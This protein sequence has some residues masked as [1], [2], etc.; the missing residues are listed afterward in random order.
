[1][2][3]RQKQVEIVIWGLGSSITIMIRAAVDAQNLPIRLGL[4][5]D[6][7]HVMLGS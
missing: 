1:M 6:K 2:L 7:A 3:R 5:A 4:T